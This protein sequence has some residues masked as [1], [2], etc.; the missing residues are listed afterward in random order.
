MDHG[1]KVFL[2]DTE[3]MK[4]IARNIAGIF[5]YTGVQQISFDGLEGA[6]STGLG[7][8]GLSLM[9]KEWYDNLLPEYRNCINDASMT[10]II[11]GIL[12]PG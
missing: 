5:N 9:M 12:L 2:S 4:E 10:T 11:T 6:W 3:L 7:Q 8:Y 1:Y